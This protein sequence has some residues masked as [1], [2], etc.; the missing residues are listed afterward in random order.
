MCKQLPIFICMQGRDGKHWASSCDLGE[1]VYVDGD[2]SCLGKL[3]LLFIF[4][5]LI[6]RWDGMARLQWN[7]TKRRNIM[8]YLYLR[9]T[10]R[11]TSK[12]M[13]VSK[14]IQYLT[15]WCCKLYERVFGTI[16]IKLPG[17]FVIRQ[18]NFLLFW[19][20]AWKFFSVGWCWICSTTSFST[21]RR[22]TL[23]NSK[24]N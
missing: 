2:E 6:D 7:I 15:P 3:N 17:S 9:S 21:R 24:I 1:I 8:S 16:Y 4:D 12:Q 19:A 18:L 13:T 5:F 20:T 11:S 14:Y 22:R 23:E 10:T